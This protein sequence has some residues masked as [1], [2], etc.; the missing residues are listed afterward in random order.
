ML[1][2]MIDQKQYF[3]DGTLRNSKKEKEKKVS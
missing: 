2:L 1:D 3:D